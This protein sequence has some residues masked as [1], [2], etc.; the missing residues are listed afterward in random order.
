[1]EVSQG[2]SQLKNAAQLQL[3]GESFASRFLIGSA[4]YPSPAIMRDAVKA[5]AAS[6]VTLSL[7]RQD[8]ANRLGQNFWQEIQSLG[9]QLLPNTAGCKSAEEAINLAE[10]S[11]EIF[12]TAWI[13]LEVIGDDYNLQPD[14][15]ELLKAASE[16]IKRGF[17][18]LP[19]STDD[20][21][22]CLRLRDAGCEAIMPWGSP[23]GTGLGLMNDYAL[24]TLRERLPDTPLII[25]AGLGAPSDAAQ[26]M[27]LGFDGVLLNTAVAKALDPVVMASAF[28]LAIESGRLAYQAGLILPRQNASPSTS[29]IGQ[30]F[31]QHK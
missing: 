27:E 11:R 25:D 20:L 1:M 8:P 10:M 21:I 2:A 13:K 4:L 18:V 17:K 26:A 30:P 31:W 14:P 16:L 6:L 19:Y 7:R 22:L 12:N 29:P 15:F 9:C 28:K 24:R 3:Y 5:S 23:I